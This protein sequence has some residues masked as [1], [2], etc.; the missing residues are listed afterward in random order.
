VTKENAR[1]CG[2]TRKGRRKKRR[3]RNGTESWGIKKALR[4]TIY[5]TPKATNPRKNEK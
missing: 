4:D 1:S 3:G 2:H 5:T